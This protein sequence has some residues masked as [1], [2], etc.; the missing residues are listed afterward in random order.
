VV[1]Q[2][3]EHE[4]RW[5]TSASL[6]LFPAAPN[7]ESKNLA[8]LVTDF[9]Q[10]LEKEW[11]LP[12]SDPEV[13]LPPFP[14]PLLLTKDCY[15]L[16]DLTRFCESTSGAI[17]SCLTI[18]R[19]RPSLMVPLGYRNRTCQAYS[20][21]DL[22]P[23]LEQWE[24][25]RILQMLDVGW[26]R[27]FPPACGTC[28]RCRQAVAPYLPMALVCGKHHDGVAN[29]RAAFRYFLEGI[30]RLGS[31]RAWWDEYQK[32]HWG[33]TSKGP[34]LGT[35]VIYLLDRRLL[36]LSDDELLSAEPL[37]NSYLEDIIRLWHNRRQGEYEQFQQ[38]MRAAS[39]K[40]EAGHK[41]VLLMFGLLIFLKY[42]LN[43]IT[44]LGRRLT[45]EELQLA[46][47]DHR[48]MTFHLAQGVFL[49]YP[50]TSDI[51]VG[52]VLLDDIR[53]YIWRYAANKPEDQR[54]RQW[55]MGPRTWS[56]W[57]VAVIEQALAAPM[58]K[59]GQ[60]ILSRRPETEGNLKSPLLIVHQK[61]RADG[62]YS[63]LP[64]PIQEQVMT[65]LTYCHRGRQAE[66]ATLKGR[67]RELMCFFTWLRKQGKLPHYP[68]WSADYGQGIFRAYA[69]SECAGDMPSTRNVRLVHL[70]HFFAT[71][72]DL[73]YPV[74]A[75]YRLLYTLGRQPAT[76][77]REVPPEAILDRVFRD[78]VC[79]LDYDPFA[80]LALTI[81]Y[82]CGTRATETCELHLFCILEDRDGH[83][84]L[85]IPKGKSKEERP[86]PIVELGMGPLLEFMDEV[87]SLRL[88]PDGTPST[89]GKTNYRYLQDNP[90]RAN[91]WHYLF[92]RAP[93]TD[94]RIKVRGPL[95]RERLEEAL[96]EAHML[97]ARVDPSGL[98][99]SETYRRVCQHRRR[100]GQ[101]CRYFAAREGITACPLCHA[102]L[103]GRL[104]AKCTRVLKE[105]FICDGVAHNGEAFCPKCD[106]PLADCVSITTHV[107]RHNSVSRAHRAG[108][109]L[110]HNMRLHGHKTVPMHLRYLH[111]L[112]E[113]TTNEVRQIFAEKRLRD[114][115]QL[116]GSTAGTIVED[117]TAYTVS[118]EQY[119]GLTLQ[120][121]LK[122]RTYGIWGGFWAGALAQRGIASPLSVE[123]E[124]V[125]PEDTYEHTVAQYWY[126][127]LGL[128]V[129]EVAFEYVTK[130]KW[131]AAVPSFLDRHK[132]EALVEF[133]LSHIQDSFKSALGQRLMETDMLEQRRFLDDLAEKLR[134]WW[135][136]L[137]TIDQLVEMFAPGGGHAFQKQLPS[138]ES[139]A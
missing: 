19:I 112:L 92:D 89:L 126:E 135:Q 29:L 80:R 49:P 58:Y 71:L 96:H 106:A 11:Q 55:H 117:G 100:K 34:A 130:G 88:A 111:L 33:R 3:R 122:R 133:H 62:G 2:P 128:A 66:L 115:R 91:D 51:C 14:T 86:F 61:E 121:A 102:S 22:A 39:Y 74:P 24:W 35:L 137:G 119:L 87:V 37:C 109:S 69:A 31:V 9:F 65:Y 15:T 101:H 28:V 54:S 1:T 93:G 6:D 108:V 59:N 5:S 105:D 90:M 38:A 23:F 97:A 73:A 70:A 136:H 81:Q 82:Y 123:E 129:S 44:E 8:A 13:E 107:F 42:G 32:S 124:I 99:K 4:E 104:G 12:V 50:L 45:P 67:A 72:A 56:I 139:L 120:R 47:R 7:G 26:L 78:G 131:R 41:K 138:T 57:M 30:R 110:A 10:W 118:L 27:F 64:V 125:I 84:Y 79:R 98:F 83:A 68:H 132:I 134:P 25:K 40:E 17:K 95:S 94:E 48:L 20:K 16:A 36:R 113:D 63:L 43:S 46:C 53:Y 103:S 114:V 116:L 60:A 75:G 76:N 127:A 77:P 18:L 21:Q 85:L 52:H